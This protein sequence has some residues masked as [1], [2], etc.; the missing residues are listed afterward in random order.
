LLL[1]PGLNFEIGGERPANNSMKQLYLAVT[2]IAVTALGFAS[3]VA[4]DKM[5]G[6]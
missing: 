4:V 2:F 5:I 3:L 1:G 6:G